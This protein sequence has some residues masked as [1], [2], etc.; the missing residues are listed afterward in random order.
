MA[1]V[2][3]LLT[4]ASLSLAVLRLPHHIPDLTLVPVSSHLT[5]ELPTIPSQLQVTEV[6]PMSLTTKAM[7]LHYWISLVQPPDPPALIATLH[8]TGNNMIM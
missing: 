2:L 3:A 1:V 8:W 5:P 7:S 4:E 6:S